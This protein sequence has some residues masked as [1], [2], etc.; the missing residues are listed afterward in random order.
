MKA[1]RLPVG[2]SPRGKGDTPGCPCC[3]RTPQ[4]ISK[5]ETGRYSDAPD[6]AWS[7][8]QAGATHG[9]GSERTR[10]NKK[11]VRPLSKVR[12][13]GWSRVP[14][15]REQGPHRD[16][17]SL[18]SQPEPPPATPGAL[19][20]GRGGHWGPHGSQE[21]YKGLFRE[22]LQGKKGRLCLQPSRQE[23]GSERLTHENREGRG[24]AGIKKAD[25][26]L[27]ALASGGRDHARDR[28]GGA[29]RWLGRSRSPC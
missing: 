17:P 16:S 4:P 29:G 1:F 7:R 2:E 8:M 21:E 12:A 24:A 27:P 5:D 28:Q 18:P 19:G 15:G 13:R 20:A 9:K 25:T 22:R 11:P 23:P 14:T 26:R 3:P 6:H 10:G